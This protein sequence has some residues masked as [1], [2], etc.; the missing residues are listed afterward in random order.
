MPF[1]FFMVDFFLLKPRRRIY[2]E[3]MKFMKTKEVSASIFK[4]CSFMRFMVKFQPHVTC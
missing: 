4:I 3:V 1:M 2:P